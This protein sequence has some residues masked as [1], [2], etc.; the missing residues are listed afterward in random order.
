MSP[1]LFLIWLQHKTS[2]QN[3][4]QLPQKTLK[5]LWMSCLF[6]NISFKLKHCKTKK[7]FC[8]CLR[9]N[10]HFC[11]TPE[12]I[13]KIKIIMLCGA[14]QGPGVGAMQGPGVGAMQGPGVPFDVSHSAG[15]SPSRFFCRAYKLRLNCTGKNAH[16]LKLQ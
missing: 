1:L 12:K 8:Q 7:K 9:S 11:F 4:S 16:E 13:I 6:C 3:L 5:S 10:Y 15:V 14:M 2:H